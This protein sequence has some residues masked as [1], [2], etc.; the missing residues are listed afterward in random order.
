MPPK[1]TSPEIR[2]MRHVSPCPNT[3][4]WFWTGAGV[5]QYGTFKIGGAGTKQFLAHRFSYLIHKGPI[6]DGLELD[7]L[8]RVRCCVN[9]DHLEPV[10]RQ[11][12]ILR[13]ALSTR[14]T[15]KCRR[16]H[17]FTIKNTW[18]EKTGQRHCRRCHAYHEAASRSRREQAG[19]KL[20]V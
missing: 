5:G 8:C 17:E 2:F 12:N 9:P 20:G 1:P 7:H 4:C 3:G 10:T 15:N 14:Q 19:D 6:P 11:E 16:G 13:G 18:I